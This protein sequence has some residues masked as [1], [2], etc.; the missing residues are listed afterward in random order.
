MKLT[1]RRSDHARA[2]CASALPPPEGTYSRFGVHSQDFRRTQTTNLSRHPRN[3]VFRFT[4]PN[5]ACMAYN[6][7]DGKKRR[8]FLKQFSCETASRRPL[9]TRNIIREKKNCDEN[10]TIAADDAAA[11]ERRDRRRSVDHNREICGQSTAGT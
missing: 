1:A 10:S 7:C 9:R 5:T 11:S 3:V 2:L 4:F 6:Y 8:F